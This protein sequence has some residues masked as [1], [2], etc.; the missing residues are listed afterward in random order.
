MWRC[1]TLLSDLRYLM[2]YL[3]RVGGASY[4]ATS[5]PIKPFKGTLMRCPS[6]VHTHTERFIYRI[7]RIRK[8]L[9][10]S[11]K[12]HLTLYLGAREHVFRCT[13]QWSQIS[14]DT[15]YWPS[16]ALLIRLH[17]LAT[18]S[19]Y[20]GALNNF[21]GTRAFVFVPD[22]FTLAPLLVAAFHA[23]FV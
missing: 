18:N 6:R 4:S 13:G 23:S 1:S 8:T 19:P 17:S 16:L 22:K 12:R 2:C 20:F 7:G 5:E 3:W 21:M 10:W 11:A 14:R 15:A 9:L